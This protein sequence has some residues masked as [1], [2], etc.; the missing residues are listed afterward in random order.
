MGDSTASLHRN[1]DLLDTEVIIV[2]AGF[3]GLAAAHALHKSGI[4]SIVLEARHRVGGRSWSKQLTSCNGVVVSYPWV[5]PRTFL[6]CYSRQCLNMTF[7]N[8]SF[9]CF[10]ESNLMSGLIIKSTCAR[11]LT[12]ILSGYGCDLD[13]S[14]DAAKRLCIG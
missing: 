7:P 4:K 5:E 1:G 6:Y 14:D 9:G 2:G 12:C 13:K 10:E 8:A 11:A 3:S